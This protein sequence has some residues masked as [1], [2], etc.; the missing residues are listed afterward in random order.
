MGPRPADEVA[1]GIVDGDIAEIGHRTD[2]AAQHLVRR[3]AGHALAEHCRRGD[4]HQV[5]LPDQIGG[6]DVGILELLIKVP[7]DQLD[8]VFQLAFAVR[9]GALAKFAD[10]HGCHTEDARDQQHAAQGQPQDRTTPR[11]GLPAV[12]CGSRHSGCHRGKD[13]AHSPSLEEHE[14]TAQMA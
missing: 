10:G 1:I 8:R 5:H 12:P 9:Q 13:L 11:Q 4:L 7:G 2:L 3:G 6:D 14:Y